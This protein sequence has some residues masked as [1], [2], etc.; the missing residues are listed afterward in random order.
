MCKRKI[1]K[2]AIIAFYPNTIPVV[3]DDAGFYLTLR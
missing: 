1:K 3:V 2:Y